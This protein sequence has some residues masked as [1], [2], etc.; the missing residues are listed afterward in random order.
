MSL[1][2]SEDEKMFRILN[3]KIEFRCR[4]KKRENEHH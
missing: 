2:F 3:V 4:D 1:K